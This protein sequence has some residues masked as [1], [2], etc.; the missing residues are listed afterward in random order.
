MKKEKDVKTK[1]PVR[2]QQ[3]IVGWHQ[4]TEPTRKLRHKMHAQYAGG[5]FENKVGETQPMNLIDRYV[6]IIAPYLVSQNPRV[7]IDPKRGL[8][9][10]RS[11]ARTLELALEHLFMEIELSTNTLRP[12]VINSLFSMGITKTGIVSDSQVEIFGYLHDVGQ[13]FCDSIDYDDYIGD[14]RARNRQEME[15]EGNA[16]CLPLEYICDSGLF[17]HYD[18]LSTV[19]ETDAAETIP[20]KIAKKHM[21]PFEHNNGLRK[22]VWLND[23][24]V[25][26]EGIIITIPNEGQGSK[27]MRTVEY[28]GPEDGPYDLLTYKHFPNS[29]L[30]VPPIYNVLNLNN[31]INRLVSKMKKQAEREKKVMLYELSGAED[32][33]LIKNTP[34]GFTAGVKNTDAFKEIEFGGV[35]DTN[36]P[37]V[38]F[39]E[40]QYSI[41][42][43]NLYTIGGR[44]SQAETLGQEQM[45]Q[46]NA[47]KQLQDMVLQVHRFTRNITRKL[48]WYLWSDPFIQIP[49]IKELGDFKLKVEYTPDVR[50]GD[51]FDYGFDIEPYSMSQMSPET[52][53]QR[54]MQLVGQVVLPTA[55]L[56]AAQGSQLNVTELVTECA[57]HLDVRNLDKWWIT[58]IP[59]ETQ[60]NPYSPAQGSPKSGQGDGRFSNSDNDGSNMNNMLQHMNRTAGESSSESAPGSTT[61]GY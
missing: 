33:E 54:L 3:A 14:Y 57:R 19:R 59:Q 44:E 2:V 49:V 32:A 56:A 45:L 48:A 28:D 7:N 9:A 47:S 43:G 24:W 38:Q 60:M 18:N 34:D 22:R 1:F 53:Y 6:N 29:V 30:P 51:F 41:Q 27:I 8:Q 52:R 12:A 37:F 17:K 5:Y 16:Y 61:K 58:G 13:P 15:I 50:E 55:Q 10:S 35:S 42:G 26:D 25:P 20:E 39:L 11:F 40:Q 31:I 36:F 21:L 23:V 4:Y 46:A